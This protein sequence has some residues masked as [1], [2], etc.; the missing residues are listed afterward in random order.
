MQLL[1][2]FAILLVLLALLIPQAVKI[3]REYQRLVV[4]RLGRLLATKGP[5]LVLLIPL[6]DRAVWVDLREFFLE[7]P[8]Q[9]CITE[10]NAPISIDFI[11]FYKV[12]EPTMSVVQVQNF[13]GAAQGIA[14]TTLRAVVGD[15]MLD[16]VLAKRDEINEIL[17]SKL[18]EVTSRWG[19]KV[20]N[21]EI[22]EIIPPP[23]VQ[24]AMTRQMSA[25]RTRRAVVTEA[26]GRASA[27][28]T[29]TV[30]GRPLEDAELV[31]L[32]KGGDVQAYGE[33]VE[34]YRD[35]AFRIAYLITRHAADAEDAAQD[36]FVKAYYALGRFRTEGAFRPWI[37]RIVSNEAR[38][39]RRAAGRRER[40]RLRLADGGPSGGT[41]LSPE[42]TALERETSAALL[43]A[44]ES[45]P[46]RDRDV[47]ACR[48]LL[49]LSEAETARVLGVR[50]GTVK[51]RLSRALTR[52][53]S[54]IPAELS[55]MR[56]G[57]GDA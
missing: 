28:A 13:V 20:T 32:A 44:V 30:E 15:I 4:F 5:G 55:D 31:E 14:T 33:L 46:E 38:N 48:Y 24:E 45:L 56:E 10:D 17:R 8:R 43:S 26:E 27:R 21:V 39:R 57:S 7:V 23:S 16:E 40:L 22:R 3:V 36:G 47:I 50:P 9:D 2:G 54:A 49:E 35:A 42:A 41:A 52:L 37:L 18:D 25:E 29:E 1:I 11:V 6:V 51:S 34:R 19:V 53:R 12:V